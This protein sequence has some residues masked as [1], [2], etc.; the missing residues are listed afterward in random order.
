MAK[1]EKRERI[2]LIGEE[3]RIADAKNKT[4]TGFTGNVVGETRNTITI[5]TQTGNKTIIKEQVEIE[6]N[7]KKIQGKNITGRVEER[8]KQQ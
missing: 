5:K 1:R 2:A 7:G 6:I 4:L 3:I 8:I